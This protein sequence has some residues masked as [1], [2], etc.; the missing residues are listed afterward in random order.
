MV[1]SDNKSQVIEDAFENFLTAGPQK[2]VPK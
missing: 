1:E 2:S